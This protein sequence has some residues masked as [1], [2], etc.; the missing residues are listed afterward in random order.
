MHVARA[1]V[2]A[3]HAVL[4]DVFR[5]V[6]PRAGDVVVRAA[7]AQ[8]DLEHAVGVVARVVLDV[9]V[10]KAGVADV[11]EEVAQFRHDL[12]VVLG[13]DGGVV[14]ARLR[15]VLLEA[16]VAKAHHLHL[17]VLVAVGRQHAHLAVRAGDHVL[18]NHDVG[19]ARTVNFAEDGRGFVGSVG[20]VDL[21][22]AVERIF[23]V[24]DA[25]R[26][27]DDDGI[28]KTDLVLAEFRSGQRLRGAERL[29]VRDA[30]LVAHFIEIGLGD[31]LVPQIGVDVRRDAVLG[32][33]ALDFHQ[34]AGVVVGAAHDDA[35]LVRVGVC[36]VRDGPDE[37]VGRVD[38]GDVGALDD[39]AVHRVAHAPAAERVA[40]HAV[41]LVERARHGIAVHIRA[42]ENRHEGNG[43]CHEIRPPEK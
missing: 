11:L 38:V 43:L 17:A 4:D 23:P 3:E 28:R 39:A 14:A 35:G 7:L 31:E 15:R 26:R 6:E 33:A 9:E 13:D 42:D 19:I 21:F 27:L 40:H 12:L 34:Q 8:V 18:Q 1:E 16:D 41:C 30:V 20:H 32:Q 10:R 24:E 37:R 5:D 29:R 2:A 36:E 25:R 22:H